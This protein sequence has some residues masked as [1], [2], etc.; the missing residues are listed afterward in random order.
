ME[1]K[2]HS[3]IATWLRRMFFNP[4]KEI[5]KLLEEQMVSPVSKCSGVSC[6]TS[7]YDRV[8]NLHDFAS[9]GY[10]RAGIFTN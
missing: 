4:S 7:C 10:H 2:K 9:S 1:I 8:C 6:K 3:T 5:D